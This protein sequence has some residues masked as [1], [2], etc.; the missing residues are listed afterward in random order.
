[1]T[2]TPVGTQHVQILD[3][4]DG[5]HFSILPSIQTLLNWQSNGQPQQESQTARSRAT[6]RLLQHE[7]AV[8]SE[9]TRQNGAYFTCFGNFEVPKFGNLALC[10][11]YHINSWD[12]WKMSTTMTLKFKNVCFNPSL[13]LTGLGPAF[14]CKVLKISINLKTSGRRIGSTIVAILNKVPFHKKNNV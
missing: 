5:P 7:K 6:S 3:A 13:F 12:Q 2:Q 10:V 4:A 9:L 1:M 14:T 11:W 8:L